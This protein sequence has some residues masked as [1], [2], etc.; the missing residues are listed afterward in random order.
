MLHEHYILNQ[1]QIQP[2]RQ[3]L[4][5]PLSRVSQFSES[6]GLRLKFANI[7][8]WAVAGSSENPMTL[9]VI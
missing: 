1:W 4:T 2:I 9:F 5:L 8:L 7:L 6:I 3:L